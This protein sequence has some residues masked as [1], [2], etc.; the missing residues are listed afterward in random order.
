MT[1]IFISYSHKDKEWLDELKKWLKPLVRNKIL[2]AWDD[3]IIKPGSIWRDEINHALR[4]AK[5]AILLVSSDFI[6]SDFINNDE[7]PQLLDNVSNSVTVFWIPIRASNYK[8]TSIERY[9]AAWD[10]S[11]P[12]NTLSVSDKEAAWVEISHKLVSTISVL[13]KTVDLKHLELSLKKCIEAVIRESS[14]SQLSVFS[15]TTLFESL[16]VSIELDLNSSQQES[17][18]QLGW[19]ASER[20]A[21]RIWQLGDNVSDIVKELLKTYSEVLEIDSKHLK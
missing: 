2:K 17:L 9:Q 3:T 12:L 6:D 15:I 13:T 11:K 19:K 8:Y 5:L 20:G 4:S 18:N 21:M 7:L 16:I 10:P 1:E 14:S